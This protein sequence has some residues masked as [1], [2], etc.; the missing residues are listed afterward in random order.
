MFVCGCG[1]ECLFDCVARAFMVEIL[2]K[3]RPPYCA[4]PKNKHTLSLCLSPELLVEPD[5]E[6]VARVAQRAVAAEPHVGVQ[7]RHAPEARVQ[8]AVLV[9]CRWWAAGARVSVCGGVVGRL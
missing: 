1:C 6:R 5:G 2:L 8:H 7:R 9:V 4:P 3:R